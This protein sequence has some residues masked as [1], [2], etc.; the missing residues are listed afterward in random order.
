MG[1]IKNVLFICYANI[2]RSPAAEVL[3][4][5][6]AE[7]YNLDGVTFDSAGWHKAFDTAVR[8]TKDYAKEKG[9]DMS[10]FESKTITREMIEKADLIIGMEKYHLLKTRKTFKDLREELKKKLFTLKQFNEAERKDWN[11]PDPYETG[12]EN[13][14]RII[15]I[16]EDNV[17][18]LVKKIIEINN[19]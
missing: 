2:C 3:A 6:Y 4:R 15:K 11:I 18:K 9:I 1:K 16:V 17:E 14:F 5:H 10:D 12:R 13:Y 19:T 8:D 7:K